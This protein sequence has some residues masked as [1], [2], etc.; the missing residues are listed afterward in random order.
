MKSIK[1]QSTLP[2][3]GSD[4]SICPQACTPTAFQSTL[5]TRGSDAKPCAG[6]RCASAFQST[7][8]TRGSDAPLL[9]LRSVLSGFNPR[10][11]RGGA[12]ST[13]PHR[14]WRYKQFQSTLPTRGSDQCTA[15]ATKT[16][17]CFNPRSPRGGATRLSAAPAVPAAHVSIHAPHEGERPNASPTT[18]APSPVSI[19]APHEGERRPLGFAPCMRFACFNPRSPRGGATVRYPNGYTYN[20]GFQSTLPTRGSDPHGIFLQVHQIVFQSTLPT[21]GSD[22]MH[23]RA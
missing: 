10:S 19:H 23:R 7:L 6:R 5:P 22:F 13:P 8:P 1:F 3:R 12:T 14:P 20:A 21:R 9:I 16:A 18:G 15:A 4:L 17:R 2:T 11:P